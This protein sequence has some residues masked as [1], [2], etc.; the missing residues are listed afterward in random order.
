MEDK[1]NKV[2]NTNNESRKER[3]NRIVRR[4]WWVILIVIFF[5]I[6]ILVGL[7]VGLYFAFRPDSYDLRS[8]ELVLI[9]GNSKKDVKKVKDDI[10]DGGNSVG[11]FYYAEDDPVVN[12]LM[13][14]DTE[15]QDGENISDEAPMF[16]YLENLTKPGNNP[17]NMVWYAVNITSS[18]AKTNAPEYLFLDEETAELD[19]YFEY[20]DHEDEKVKTYTWD[21]QPDSGY[22]GEYLP[23]YT[24]NSNPSG[25]SLEGNGDID[26]PI[27]LDVENAAAYSVNPGQMMFFSQAQ[28]N[29]SMITSWS[30]VDTTD[31]TNK[32]K[33]DDNAYAWIN[34]LTE[35]TY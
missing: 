5:V 2:T 14:D 20:L 7:G 16:K 18:D 33:Y 17:S 31:D 15:G 23:S 6:A 4:R 19:Q 11:V 26:D 28:G 27:L 30:S 3:V 1:N 25:I 29:V 32:S 34:E 12:W 10:K 35:N 24:N 8:N 13:W 22:V 9:D 21:Y